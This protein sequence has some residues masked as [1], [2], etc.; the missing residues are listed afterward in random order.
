M[1]SW[2]SPSRRVR[3]LKR[4]N[5]A[6]I[7]RDAVERDAVERD[8][9]R[10]PL[11]ATFEIEDGEFFDPRREADDDAFSN[12]RDRPQKS[13]RDARANASSL[14]SETSN[15]G[16]VL[17]AV[18]LIAGST[19]GAGALALPETVSPAGVLPSSFVLFG[20]GALLACEALL[21]AEVNVAMMRERDEYRLMHGRG[22]SPV[23]ISL[24]EMAG[25]TLG[26]EGASATAATYL[27]LS[28]ALLT[29]YVSKSGMIIAD[30]FAEGLHETIDPRIAS[31]AFAIAMGGALAKGGVRLADAMNQAL[32]SVLLTSF[33]ALIVGG[34]R[35][36]EWS[37]VDFAGNWNNAPECVPV[38]FLA[39]V[40]HDLIPVICSYLSGD[41]KKIRKA[42]VLGSAAPLLMFLAWDAVAL[43]ARAANGGE[44]G[45]PLAALAAGDDAAALI[46]GGFSFCAI[47]TSFIGTSIGVSEFVRPK[48]ERWA[49]EKTTRNESKS[50]TRRRLERDSEKNVARASSYVLILAGPVAIAVTNPD[51]F[52]PATNFAG[53]Y[54]MTAMFGILPPVMAFKMRA[55]IAQ[56]ET[57]ERSEKKTSSSRPTLGR[58]VHDSPGG[59]GSVNVGGGTPALAAL[60]F[61]AC[62]IALGQLRA[63]ISKTHPGRVLVDAGGGGET[64]ASRAAE[65]F[66]ALARLAVPDEVVSATA[67]LAGE[68]W[69]CARQTLLPLFP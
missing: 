17:G 38:V 55:R 20:C 42:V 1:Q 51:V 12:S 28:T 19:V 2:S 30:I 10:P 32:T 33:C 39:L 24:S 45:D 48:L 6:E 21:L 22:H 66:E 16:S 69:E 23:V 68:T 67:A 25:R 58:R 64:V 60:S 11:T 31:V 40:Y 54:G 4:G 65:A 41:S 5:S 59:G 61:A 56:R 18:A 46:V 8:A 15:P 7:E 43:G 34:A 26:K 50:E 53:A 52:L 35:R 29:A 13:K 37:A 27:F 9:R 36:A 47:A 3:E 57:S 62:G 49:E 63:D 14:T 44:G